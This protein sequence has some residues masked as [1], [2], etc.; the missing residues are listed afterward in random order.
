M[1]HQRYR[2]VRAQ[3]LAGVLNQSHTLSHYLSCCPSLQLAGLDDTVWLSLA[4]LEDEPDVVR[5]QH[6]ICQLWLTLGSVRQLICGHRERPGENVR[7]LLRDEIVKEGG[8]FVR[9][10]FHVV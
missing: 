1:I 10:L 6:S 9:A 2:R 3:Q 5:Q 4:Q 7:V 8:G